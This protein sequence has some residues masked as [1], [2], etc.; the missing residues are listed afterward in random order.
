M[1]NSTGNFSISL[2]GDEEKKQKGRISHF[3][4]SVPDFSFEILEPTKSFNDLDSFKDFITNYDI[5][6]TFF[7]DLNWGDI[8]LTVINYVIDT[9]AFRQNTDYIFQQMKHL[10]H[11]LTPEVFLKQPSSIEKNFEK[12]E[13]KAWFLIFISKY[14]REHFQK[15]KLQLLGNMINCFT[16]SDNAFLDKIPPIGTILHYHALSKQPDYY[17]L[18]FE[19]AIIFDFWEVIKRGLTVKKCAHCKKLFIPQSRSDEIY[20]GYPYKGGRTCR[21]M[22]YE[23]KTNADIVLKTYRTVYK[24]QQARK[25]RNK[26]NICNIEEKFQKWLVYAQQQVKQCQN[27]EISLE[28]MKAAISATDWMK[29]AGGD[30][31]ENP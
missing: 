18:K 28:D 19:D 24:T 9:A 27:K 10:K 14:L 12:I 13:K 30:T 29:E 2:F 8:V 22:G 6:Y 31:H 16:H 26:N 20:C 21:Q 7:F 23:N 25:T 3:W 1:A 5:D 11:S 4:G 15:D 17:F